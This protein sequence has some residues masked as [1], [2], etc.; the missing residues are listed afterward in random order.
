MECLLRL[1]HA[2]LEKSDYSASGCC[3][4]TSYILSTSET[5]K[6]LH[7]HCIKSKTKPPAK[8]VGGELA[9][10]VTLVLPLVTSFPGRGEQWAG[11]IGLWAAR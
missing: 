10:A 11:R 1:L 5:S 2:Q 6:L 3:T 9:Q 8:G 7:V 4:L